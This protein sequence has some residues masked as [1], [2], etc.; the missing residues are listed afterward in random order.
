MSLEY[1]RPRGVPTLP[2]PVAPS[3]WEGGA[4]AIMLTRPV[5]GRTGPA[6]RVRRSANQW[7][8]VEPTTTTALPEPAMLLDA[9]GIADHEAVRGSGQIPTTVGVHGTGAVAEQVASTMAADWSVLPCGVVLL[10]SPDSGVRWQQR[11]RAEW[12]HRVAREHRQQRVRTTS[13]SG[14]G[15]L[16]DVVVVASAT[17]EP[18]RLLTERLTANRVPHVIVRAH[19]DVATIGPWVLPGRTACLHCLDLAA[20]ETDPDHAEVMVR[21]SQLPA[22][23]RHSVAEWVAATLRLQWWAWQDAGALASLGLLSFDTLTGEVTRRPT[24]AHRTCHCAMADPQSSA[25]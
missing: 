8:Q 25:A 21:L 22:L 11:L 10:E 17:A 19:R 20:A 18:D 4:D 2:R 23:V 3:A 14:L 6:I 7:M 24:V 16:S 5:A 13:A 1:R 12:A 15:V 9:L